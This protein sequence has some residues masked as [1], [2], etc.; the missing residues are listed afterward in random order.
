MIIVTGS[1]DVLA[2]H[3]A[4]AMSLCQQHV[5]RSRTEQGCISHSVYVEADQPRRF[6]FFEQWSDRAALAQHFEQRSAVEFVAALRKLLIKEP[7]MSIY[8]A[9]QLR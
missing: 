5:E 3:E 1:V 6:F 4:A 7:V 2:G 8:E 9:Q